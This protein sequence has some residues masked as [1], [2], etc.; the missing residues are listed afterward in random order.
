MLFA[1]VGIDG[2]G[3]GKMLAGIVLGFFAEIV[4]GN[5]AVITHHSG[6]N[7]TSC[8]LLIGTV[9]IFH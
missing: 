2:G 3:F 7:L 4:A 6:P 1:E 5:R 9:L 8:P